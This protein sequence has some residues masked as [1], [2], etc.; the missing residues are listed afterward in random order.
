VEVLVQDLDR[1]ARSLRNWQAED[2]PAVTLLVVESPGDLLRLIRSGVAIHS[3]NLG[4]LHYRSGTREL[5]PGFYLDDQARADLRTMLDMG[6]DIEVQTVPA[7]PAIDARS[8]LE[9]S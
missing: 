5:W 6:I 4:G 7:A 2:D 8:V 3:V 1:A 9:H